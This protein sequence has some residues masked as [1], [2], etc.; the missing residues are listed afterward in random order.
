M[1]TI[2]PQNITPCCVCL[3]G[4]G[5]MVLKTALLHY[6]LDFVLSLNTSLVR[7]YLFLKIFYFR[8]HV[9]FPCQEIFLKM[10]ST[11]VSLPLNFK[12]LRFS[13][14]LPHLFQLYHS[15]YLQPVR[16]SKSLRK[17]VMRK[18]WDILSSP[19]AGF[20]PFSAPSLLI[21]WFMCLPTCSFSAKY[22]HMYSLISTSVI[23]SL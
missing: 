11:L 1:F 19:F 10:S 17:S 3:F 23:E 7:L 2:F 21:P 6:C 8:S 12:G 13:C 18:S 20:L 9:S 5:K 16:K 22:T 15:Y 4:M 14:N